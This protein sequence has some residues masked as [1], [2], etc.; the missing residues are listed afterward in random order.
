MANNLLS[1]PP[2][3]GLTHAGTW[4]IGKTTKSQE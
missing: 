4:K 2:R 3:P 1:Q